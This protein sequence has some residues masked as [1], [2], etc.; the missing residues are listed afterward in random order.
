MILFCPFCGHKLP[1][2]LVSGMCSCS[3]CCRVFDSSRHNVVLSA[4]WLS[5]KLH[6]SDP[7]YLVDRLGIS[8]QDAEFIIEHVAIG[9][10]T[11]QEFEVIMNA[12]LCADHRKA[13]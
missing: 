1:S 8:F 7:H 4:S 6:I 11:H 3:N 9:C 13:S 2:P 12:N 5:R 10:C